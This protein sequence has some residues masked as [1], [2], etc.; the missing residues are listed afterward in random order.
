AALARRADRSLARDVEVRDGVTIT[1]GQPAPAGWN[2]RVPN[3]ATCDGACPDSGYWFAPPLAHDFAGV[4]AHPGMNGRI[5]LIQ[6]STDGRVPFDSVLARFIARLGAPSSEARAP[7][8][9]ARVSW[10]DS[11][12]TVELTGTPGAASRSWFLVSDDAAA[13]RAAAASATPRARTP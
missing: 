13:T 2:S 12:T 10:Q 7:G 9:D 5:V 6:G 11:V 3:S 8:G 4:A 1:L